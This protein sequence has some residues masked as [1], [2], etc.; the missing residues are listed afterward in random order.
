MGS[1]LSG[2]ALQTEKRQGQNLYSSCGAL[3]IRSVLHREVWPLALWDELDRSPLD[4]KDMSL[5]TYS[6]GISKHQA[7]R[8]PHTSCDITKFTS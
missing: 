2:V 3:Y 8:S 7:P 5:S 1:E 6:R 4:H